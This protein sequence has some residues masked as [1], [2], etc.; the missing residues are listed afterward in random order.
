MRRIGLAGVVLALGFLTIVGSAPASTL[1]LQLKANGSLKGPTTV[2][3]N[4]CK[5]GYEKIELPP[6]AQLETLNKILPHTKY[7]EKGVGGKPTIQLSGVNVQIVNGEGKTET[8]NGEGNL[9]IGYDENL[10][11][12]SQTGSHNVILGEEQTFTSYGGILAGR[13]NTIIAPFASVTGG[14]SNIASGSAASI[15]GGGSNFASAFEASVSGG[16]G[17]TASG[18]EASVSGGS[19]NT[20]S[21]LDASI[22]AGRS[23][24]ASGNF[25]SVS[26]GGFS[27]ATFTETSV[28]GGESNWA[29]G[30][31]ASVSGGRNNTAEAKWSSIFGSTHLTATKEFE[32]IP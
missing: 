14:S 4:T 16:G 2:G 1:C 10:P 21:G 17:N 15:T 26:G 7:D 31:D 20:A 28:S 27:K 18:S 11:K 12:H 5:A 3:G 29:S 22:S 8:A 32:A 25:A 6:P 13:L 19:G 9:V 30:E 23:N 24:S